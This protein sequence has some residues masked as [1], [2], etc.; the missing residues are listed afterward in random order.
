MV[1]RFAPVAGS[2]ITNSKKGGPYA[3]G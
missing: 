2:K 3:T 1:F